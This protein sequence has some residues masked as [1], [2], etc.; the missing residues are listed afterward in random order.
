LV[1]PQLVERGITPDA[2]IL[3]NSSGAAIMAKGISDE[4]RFNLFIEF[5]DPYGHQISGQVHNRRFKKRLDF[6]AATAV[7][8]WN[9]GT[10]GQPLQADGVQGRVGR[11]S[12]FV[13]EHRVHQTLSPAVYGQTPDKHGKIAFPSMKEEHEPF[14]N[15]P[16]VL[17][18]LDANGQELV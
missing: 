8:A 2:R 16:H 18:W 6:M 12:M 5:G 13:S 4:K 15:E 10:A 17:K 1:V 9:T 3:P 11:G 7:D 14:S